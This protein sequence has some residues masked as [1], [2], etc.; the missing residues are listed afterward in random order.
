MT[1]GKVA[2]MASHSSRL[3]LLEFIK[4]NPSMLD[5]FLEIG[6][7]GSLVVLNGKKEENLLDVFNKAIE[8]G[9]PCSRFYDSGHIHGKDFDGSSILTSISI[10]PANRNDIKHLTKKFQVWKS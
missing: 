8:E 7:C 1:S 2:A 6:A 10:G 5:T 4:N 3:S 9:F